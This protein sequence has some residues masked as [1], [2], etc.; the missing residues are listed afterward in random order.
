MHGTGALG[1][2]RAGRYTEEEEDGEANA[3]VFVKYNR[4]LHGQERKRGRKSKNERL[5]VKFLKKYIHY[6]K[7]M[8]QP[9]LNDE[10]LLCIF[11]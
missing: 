2:D 7:N 1:R 5:T 10:V 8:N 6:A 9:I 11:L 4:V 3:S